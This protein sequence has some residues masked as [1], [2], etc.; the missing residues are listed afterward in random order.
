VDTILFLETIV[1]FHSYERYKVLHMGSTTS[2]L[3]NN[4]RI[5]IPILCPLKC[6][7]DELMVGSAMNHGTGAVPSTTL[8]QFILK[9]R[10]SERPGAINMQC[11]SYQ[12][13]I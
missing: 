8:W 13:R 4:L 9:E 11:D 1:H 3:D 7:L 10:I 5:C 2:C 12:M 6:I